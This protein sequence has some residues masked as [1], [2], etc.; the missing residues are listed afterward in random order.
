MKCQRGCWSAVLL[1]L[2][3]ARTYLLNFGGLPSQRREA[4][5]CLRRVSDACESECERE[6]LGA[7][8]L[9]WPAYRQCRG[10]TSNGCWRLASSSV[11]VCNTCICNVTH[12]GAARDG[13]P[14]ALRPVRVTSCFYRRNKENHERACESMDPT[15]P[16]QRWF[17]KSVTVLIYP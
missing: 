3:F 9:Y 6:L 14:V 4:G 11:V 12:Q 10:Q 17:L 15:N 2:L 16:A 1:L 5:F 8:L 7:T 13:G